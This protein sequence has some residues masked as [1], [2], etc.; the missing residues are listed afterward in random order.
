M[1]QPTVVIEDNP[2][3]LR[4]KNEAKEDRH[5]TNLTGKAEYRNVVK[6]YVR[7]AGDNKCE[8][9]FL[10]QSFGIEEQV[11]QK[12][13]TRDVTRM[14]KTSE[15]ELGQPIYE[16][17]TE[18]KTEIVDGKEYIYTDTFPWIEHLKQRLK[19]KTI[20]QNYYDYC[21]KSY[22]HW[23][24]TG[25]IPIDGTPLIEWNMVSEAIKKRCI[26]MGINTVERLAEATAEATQEIGMGGQEAKRKAKSFLEV[27]GSQEAA[28]KITILETA[29][30]KDQ[31]TISELQ[32]KVAQLTALAQKKKPGR[33][34]KEA[35]A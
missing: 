9:P 3:R 8:V 35:V 10:V 21:L 33:P 14:V 25:E 31:G 22:K 23:Q 32:E 20:S 29:Q 30:E 16:Q 19:H 34:P 5:A 15:N 27:G 7:A 1:S 4:F 6:V 17:V 18:P 12:E 24:E 28:A 26:D 13:V 2:P 11:V